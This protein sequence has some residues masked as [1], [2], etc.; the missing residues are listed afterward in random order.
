MSHERV[1]SNLRNASATFYLYFTEVIRVKTA[2]PD[3]WPIGTLDDGLPFQGL[4]PDNVGTDD[5][6]NSVHIRLCLCKSCLI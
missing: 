6:G 3:M 5:I 4:V 1:H 2:G